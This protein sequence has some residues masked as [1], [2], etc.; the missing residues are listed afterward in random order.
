MFYIYFA[1]SLKNAKVYVGFSG[2]DPKMRVREHNSG[3]SGWSSA[4]KPLKLIYFEKYYCEIDAR[5]RE[6]FYKTG[7]GKNIK[8]LIIDTL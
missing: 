1:R 8:K 7:F 6:R 4:N 2:K 3:S 5:Q